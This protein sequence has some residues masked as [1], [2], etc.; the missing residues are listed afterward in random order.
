MY[1]K[2]EDKMLSRCFNETSDWSRWNFKVNHCP[3]CHDMRHRDVRVYETT[4]KEHHSI[5]TIVSIILFCS[6]LQSANVY[7]Y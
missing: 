7:R 4:D 1:L 3:K 5:I 6:I 2:G